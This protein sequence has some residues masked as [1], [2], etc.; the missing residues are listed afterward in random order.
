MELDHL[1]DDLGNHGVHG[2]TVDAVSALIGQDVVAGKQ[3]CAWLDGRDLAAGQIRALNPL[4]RGDAHDLV[5]IADRERRAILAGNRK[6]RP[7]RILVPT[8]RLRDVRHVSVVANDLI[9]TLEVFDRL[10]AGRRVDAL[11]ARHTRW[12]WQAKNGS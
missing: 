9:A 11:I 1:H 12:D 6:E 10:G 5:V 7:Q 4:H 2:N 3:A 8:A